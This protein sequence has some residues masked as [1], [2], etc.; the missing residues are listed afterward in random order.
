MAHHWADR[1]ARSACQV[2][3]SRGA[4]TS[5]ATFFLFLIIFGGLLSGCSPYPIYNSSHHAPPLSYAPTES[6]DLDPAGDTRHEPPHAGS[7]AGNALPVEPAIFAHVVE[8]Y[9]GAPYARGGDGTDGIDCSHLVCALYRDY[10]GTHLPAN[11]GHLFNLPHTVS[12][13]LLAIG[14]LVFFKFGE[15]EVSHVG[16]YIGDGRF[17]HASESHGVVI[18][19]LKDPTYRDRF[20]GA[21]RV[22]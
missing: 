21:R 13:D 2:L 10:D 3:G 6:D 17:V 8:D 12:P 19:S 16:V 4:G 14:D 22:M 7:A 20:A 18:S 15:A 1:R 5:F 9:L 11:T